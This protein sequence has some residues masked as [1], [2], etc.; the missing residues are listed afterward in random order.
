MCNAHNH[1]P[2]CPCGWGGDGHLG[3]GGGRGGS[4]SPKSDGANVHS[5]QHFLSDIRGH[6]GRIT[7]DRY[8]NPNARCPV[9]ED[10]VIFYQSEYGG[11]VFFN[12]PLGPPWEKHGCTDTRNSSPLPY[13][14]TKSQPPLR[15][16]WSPIIDPTA[17]SL[18]PHLY[19]ITVK[20]DGR[21]TILYVRKRDVPQ[22]VNLTWLID[23]TFVAIKHITNGT[24]WISVL[25]KN[26]KDFRVPAFT[27]QAS[28]N[29]WNS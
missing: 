13:F 18:T 12:P 27:S 23:R 17:E 22:D 4:H 8:V 26:F 1:R 24:Y 5:T 19:R 28:A 6:I 9:C 25:N 11:R 14:E 29:A 21:E 20:V 16:G 3:G 7:Y 2:G 10:P 15:D